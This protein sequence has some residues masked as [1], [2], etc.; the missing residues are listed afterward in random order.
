M[1]ILQRPKTPGSSDA[2]STGNSLMGQSSSTKT[3][4]VSDAVISAP[5]DSE[6]LVPQDESYENL[7]KSRSEEDMNIGNCPDLMSSKG[8]LRQY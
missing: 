7:N 8:N 5:D 1:T 2:G 4:E 3:V 6:L